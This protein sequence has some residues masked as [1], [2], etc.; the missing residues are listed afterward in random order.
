VKNLKALNHVL[1]SI[2]LDVKFFDRKG[3][4]FIKVC[5]RFGS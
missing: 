5:S 4:A 1:I 3:K 2:G